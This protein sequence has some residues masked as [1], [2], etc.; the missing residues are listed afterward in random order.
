MFMNI[1]RKVIK[2]EIE[3]KDYDFILDFESA[4]EFQESYG[5]SIFVGLSKLS[6][7]QDLLALA[8]LIASCLK[9]ES[10]KPVGM[11][12]VK[13]MDLMGGLELFMEKLTDL[14]DNSVPKEEVPT[15][16]K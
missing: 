6:E 1:K 11:D 14:V 5:K 12:F 16:K 10:G 8:C 2:M 7:E 3:G 13:S 15:K 4:I 9:D